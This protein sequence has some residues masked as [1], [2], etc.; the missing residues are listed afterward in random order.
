MGIFASKD[1]VAE[2]QTRTRG[3]LETIEAARVAGGGVSEAAFP[4]DPTQ[5]FKPEPARPLTLSFCTSI[6]RLPA[7]LQPA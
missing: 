7:R 1:E 2:A 5:H 3:Y 4:S 6:S